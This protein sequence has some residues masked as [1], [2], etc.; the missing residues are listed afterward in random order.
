MPDVSD[1]H[2]GLLALYELARDRSSSLKQHIFGHLN[3]V[4]S[5]SVL[6]PRNSALIEASCLLISTSLTKEEIDLG[7]GSAVPHWRKILDYGL[8]HRTETVQV[9]AASALKTLS[10]LVDCSTLLSR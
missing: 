5:K 4:S 9:A 7:D 10:S 8:R 1:V 6:A 2:G 3:R